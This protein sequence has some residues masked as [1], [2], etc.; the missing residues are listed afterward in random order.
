TSGAALSTYEYQWDF[1]DGNTLTTRLLQHEKQFATG[2]QFNLRLITTDLNSACADT[3]MYVISTQGA[4]GC[5]ANFNDE[6]ETIAYSPLSKIRIAYI[7]AAGKEY[8]SGIYEQPA[9]N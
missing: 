9:G 1:G 6:T 2:Q 8:T 5:E 4:G 7:D 3:L